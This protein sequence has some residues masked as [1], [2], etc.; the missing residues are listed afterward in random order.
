MHILNKLKVGAQKSHQSKYTKLV[1][2]SFTIRQHF[3]EYKSTLWNIYVQA[4]ERK[5]CGI[6]S[7]DGT[8][9]QYKALFWGMRFCGTIAAGQLDW[10]IRL[11]KK[12]KIEKVKG[13]EHL[14][15]C[16]PKWRRRRAG[17]RGKI[18]NLWGE[19]FCP[20]GLR[21]SFHG[22]LV[23]AR[24]VKYPPRKIPRL[25]IYRFGRAFHIHHSI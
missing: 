25:G 7:V 10:I 9:E 4:T 24:L 21:P 11:G 20:S 5:T 3:D 16:S 14:E 22:R 12:G 6:S 8:A 19:V 13:Q 1:L 15:S 2:A 18:A 17:K 23:F